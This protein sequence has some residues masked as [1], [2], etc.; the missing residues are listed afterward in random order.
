[1]ETTTSHLAYQENPY[2][3]GF[4]EDGGEEFQFIEDFYDDFEQV[5]RFPRITNL[6]KRGEVD[7]FLNLL[8]KGG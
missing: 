2:S 1:M 7:T 6:K 3:E 8:P 4:G 5:K